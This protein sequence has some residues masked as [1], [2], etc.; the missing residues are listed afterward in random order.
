MTTTT[1]NRRNYQYKEYEWDF[2]KDAEDIADSRAILDQKAAT[3]QPLDEV[4]E[5]LGIDWLL[6][7]GEQ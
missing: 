3:G 7:Y 2:E 4:I 1:D 5:E 6:E